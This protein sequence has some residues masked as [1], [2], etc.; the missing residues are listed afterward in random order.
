MASEEGRRVGQQIIFPPDGSLMC[1]EISTHGTH[2]LIDLIIMI[3][4]IMTFIYHKKWK[5]TGGKKLHV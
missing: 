4:I 3:I 5:V 2:I 1:A